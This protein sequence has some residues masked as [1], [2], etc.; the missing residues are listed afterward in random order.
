[1][2]QVV[3]A[4]KVSDLKVTDKFISLTVEAGWGEW[5]QSIPVFFTV[6][7]ADSTARKKYEALKKWLA[8][9]GEIAVQGQLVNGKSGVSVSASNFFVGNFKPFVKDGG[10]SNSGGKDDSDGLPF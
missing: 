7:K 3:I 1:M 5:A 4:G 10:A 6:G 8:D 9:G 2:N